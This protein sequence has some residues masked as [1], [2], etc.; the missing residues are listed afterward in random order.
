MLLSTQKFQHSFPFL[1]TCKSS[2]KHS[3]IFVSQLTKPFWLI[4]LK[5]S[6]KG[7]LEAMVNIPTFSLL[8]SVF[9]A[10]QIRVFLGRQFSF[11]FYLILM[12]V[13]FVVI[14]VIPL[15]VSISFL[16]SIDESTLEEGIIAVDL[17]CLSIWK[18]VLP[19]SLVEN[20]VS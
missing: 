2:R 7:K 14:T 9:K 12:E 19:S 13:A 1:E 10:T 17:S 8:L 11:S 20:L 16:H 15:V 4:I 5:H 3:S 6:H 18:V